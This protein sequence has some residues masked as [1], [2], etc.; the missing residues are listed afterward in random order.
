M[1]TRHTLT[2]TLRSTFSTASTHSGRLGA[3]L[4][5]QPRLA[6]TVEEVLGILRTL[7]GKESRAFADRPLGIDPQNLGGLGT[8][9]VGLSHL[10]IGGR[11]AEVAEAYVRCLRSAFPR[12]C[13]RL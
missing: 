3:S 6:Q 5:R 12:R 4:L 8:G 11:Q 13:H 2:T 10:R 1:I 9:L 7:E